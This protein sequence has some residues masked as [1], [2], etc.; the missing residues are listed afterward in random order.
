MNRHPHEPLTP[1]ERELAERLMRLG[2]HDGPA[3]ALD[4]KILAAAQRAAQGTP[5]HN[6]RR[7]LGL[8]G[9]AGGLVT[10]LGFAASL[11]LV[12]GV[13][14]QMRP[15]E[16]AYVAQPP[17]ESAEHVIL[18]ETLP[19]TEPRSPPVAPPPADVVASPEPA[20][21]HRKTRIA[22]PLATAPSAKKEHDS[23]ASAVD[24]DAADATA[25]PEGRRSAEAEAVAASEHQA[26]RQQA[27]ALGQERRQ[28]A[29]GE[30]SQARAE[31]QAADD[32][33][34]GTPAGAARRATYTRAA[35]AA[36]ERAERALQPVASA[37][38]PA[39]APPPP[40]PAESAESAESASISGGAM[41]AASDEVA[42]DPGVPSAAVLR[43]LPID[44]DALLEPT[45]WLQ[46][47][48]AR[49]AAGDTEAARESLARFRKRHPDMALPED[50][51][52][53]LEV[54]ADTTP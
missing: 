7:W 20:T 23:A 28:E 52:V 24:G 50:L 17:D 49:A 26:D 48:R 1:D 54:P 51:E 37:S 14:W 42:G 39:F 30:S 47:I 35:R 25:S 9:G 10:G 16:T 31:V 41:Q 11:T 40:A 27:R 4:A 53:L 32:A 6:R 13:V 45:D 38:A 34:D 22:E 33:A 18:V 43:S 12:L 19:G 5:R 36:P 2:P 29:A 46:R 8:S 21:P 15:M 44:E 3:P